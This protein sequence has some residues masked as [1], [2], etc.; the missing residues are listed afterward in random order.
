MAA[1]GLLA[2]APLPPVPSPSAQAH[3]LYVGGAQLDDLAV[4]G[5]GQHGPAAGAGLQGGRRGAGPWVRGQG[6]KRREKQLH[7]R[8][9]REKRAGRGHPRLPGLRRCRGRGPR[10]SGCTPW[11]SQTPPRA[12]R[13]LHANKPTQCAVSRAHVRMGAQQQGK[14]YGRDG[15]HGGA[16]LHACATG[17]SCTHQPK[18]TSTHRIP[19]CHSRW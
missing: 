16:L 17:C 18:C 6:T 15:K 3:L 9:V 1:G 8:A 4:A 7:A 19:R 13:H 10:W 2:P 11:R 12:N 5:A 14:P